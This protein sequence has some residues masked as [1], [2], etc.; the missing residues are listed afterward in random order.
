[1]LEAISPG[2]VSAIVVN[3]P[4]AAT[5][6]HLQK[7]ETLHQLGGN[8]QLNI[9]LR[10]ARDRLAESTALLELHQQLRSHPG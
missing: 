9:E 4:I 5:P 2:N 6:E 7:L 8:D 10:Y 3:K 1:M